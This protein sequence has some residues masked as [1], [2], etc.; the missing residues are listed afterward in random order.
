MLPTIQPRIWPIWYRN[1]FSS[2]GSINPIGASS[3][4]TRPISFVPCRR[5]D[6]IFVGTGGITS[7]RFGS[8]TT[9]T[10]SA[11]SFSNEVPAYSKLGLL[12]GL[13]CDGTWAASTIVWGREGSIA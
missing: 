3:T 11:T 4:F 8:G 5:G 12:A 10:V 13:L 9:C 7:S 1:S 2:G 6:A